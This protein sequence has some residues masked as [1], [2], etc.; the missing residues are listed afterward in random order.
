[1]LFRAYPRG[2]TRSSQTPAPIWCAETCAD[3]T[4]AMDIGASP[5]HDN[6]GQ[7]GRTA[8]PRD[9]CGCVRSA[10]W[11]GHLDGGYAAAAAFDRNSG[12]SGCMRWRKPPRDA[13]TTLQEWAQGRGLPTPAYREVQRHRAA[14]QSGISC[15]SRTAGQRIDRRDRPLKRAA[16]AAAA[17]AMLERKGVRYRTRAATA[18]N[19][20]TLRVCCAD[21]RAE[22]R[23]VN[24][25]Q[26]A[27]RLQSVDR[28]AEGADDAGARARD[29]HGRPGAAYIG[30]YAGNI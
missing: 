30:R 29:S 11:C 10:D 26:R 3:V 20:H 21:R 24:A 8:P 18:R 9:P 22:R 16:G 13:K 28:D 4:R 17:A 23:Q 12:A 19:Q 7:C 6:S 5:A 2:E 14:S 1:M 27:G 25:R 15:H